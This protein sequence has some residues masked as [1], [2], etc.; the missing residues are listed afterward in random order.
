[1]VDFWT[2]TCINCI[3]TFPYLKKWHE[4]YKDKGLVIVGV[5][6]PEF[7]FE[8]SLSNV[9]KAAQ[10]FKL[11]HPIVQDNDF[12]IW[13]D[14]N[15]RYWPAKYLI[16]K[17]GYVRYTHV[18]EGSYDETEKAIQTLLNETGTIIDSSIQNP[19]YEVYAK[20]PELYLGYE[21][22]Q[23]LISPE[24]ILPN[25]TQRYTIPVTPPKHYFG[26]NG[27]WLLKTEYAQP[28]KHAF[29]ELH[30]EAKEVFLVMKPLQEI[31]QQARVF[32]N[33]E[34]ITNTEAGID[35]KDGIVNISDHR[36]YKLV[37]KQQAGPAKLKLE[38][39][40]GN[41]ELYAFTFG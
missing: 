2:Y 17:D 21:R 38:F 7:E 36:L 25:K 31:S 19:S 9:K 3:R 6:T 34:L 18:G 13:Q 24:R 35:V 40:D 37:N 28:Q 23:H 33:G 14:Y 1:L 29:I 8:K 10:D 16:D 4:T 22:I 20:T 26:F 30:F 27:E 15:N 5:H 32:L 41:V 39:I 11:T 12:G